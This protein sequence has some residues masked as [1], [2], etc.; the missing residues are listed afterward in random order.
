MKN[1]GTVLRQRLPLNYMVSCFRYAI[2]RKPLVCWMAARGNFQLC[3]TRTKRKKARLMG[4]SALKWFQSQSD[5]TPEVI[6][7]AFY[8]EY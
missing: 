5:A 2:I 7:G 6:P 8:F 4:L 3:P 1:F